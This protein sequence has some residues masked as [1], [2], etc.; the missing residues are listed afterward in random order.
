MDIT[1][2]IDL[3]VHTAPDIYPRSVSDHEQ[4]SEAHEA[5]MR[6]IL[7]KSHHTL[8]AD[9]A[10]LAQT[11]VRERLGS[12]IELFGGLVLNQTIGGLN[13][14][15]VETAIEFGAKQIWMPTIHAAHCMH[16]ASHA[17]FQREVTRG[18]QGI[19]ILDQSGGLARG[20]MPILELIRD[21]DL[22]IG[23]GHLSP[24]EGL[25]LLR[26]SKDIGVSKMLV[27]HPLMSFVGYSLPDMEEAVRLGALLE[28][29]YLS[30]CPN[31]EGAVPPKAT[32][33]AIRAIGFDHCV[34]ATDGGQ[35][36]NPHPAHML[37]DFGRALIAE[38][39]AESDV[40]MMMS[41]NPGRILGLE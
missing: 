32:A 8:T 22:A 39:L 41:R 12:S 23:T 25:A 36:F 14:V 28:F 27:T 24:R 29:D 16:T 5:G 1:G 4:A 13:P 38:G 10:T 33:D 35:T 34:L 2:A 6:A 11:A 7:L 19:S 30:C 18:R 40:R 20:V 26:A 9:R 3:H 17:M 15:A 37:R 31:W 21:A